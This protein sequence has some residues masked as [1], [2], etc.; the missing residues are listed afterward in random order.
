MWIS[1]GDHELSENIIHLVMAKIPGG[2]AGVK[3][4]SLFIVPKYR[5]DTD[6]NSGAANDVTL[7]GLNHK[8][9][10]RGI[11]NCALNFGE[12]NDCTGYLI[13]AEHHGLMYMFNMMNEARIFVGLGATALGQAGYQSSLAYARERPQGRHPTDKDP[14][15]KA[16]P[17]IAHAD[18]RRL[19]VAQK[20]AV[21]PALALGFYCAKLVDVANTSNQKDEIERAKL[22]LE[23]LTPITKSWPSEFCL[24]ANKHALQVLGGAGYTRD[25]PIERHYRDNRLNPI[26]EGTHGIQ[27]LDFLNR[28]VRMLD[29]Q[30][31]SLLCHEIQ[32]T[33]SS[34]SDIDSAEYFSSKLTAAIT[35]FQQVSEQLTTAVSADPTT[36]L[37]N[38]TLYLDYAGHLVM[39]WMHLRILKA[40]SGWKM[41]IS[42]VFLSA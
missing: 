24:E 4:I 18:I 12:N 28:K 31:L 9:G 16:I 32:Q 39:A 21:E 20:A 33:I 19:L 35:E 5:L 13:G 17:I 3:G 36:G 14:N 15:S 40:L 38:A 6:G 1:C 7:A 23:V 37:A 30:G 10:Y 29:G 42:E 25:Y 27:G 41:A 2:P 8:M 34:V 26:H 22:L 11:T